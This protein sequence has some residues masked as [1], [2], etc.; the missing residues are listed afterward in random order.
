MGVV[1]VLAED[2]K[3]LSRSKMSQKCSCQWEERQATGMT[4]CEPDDFGKTLTATQEGKLFSLLF[5]QAAAWLKAK[6]V[7]LLDTPNQPTALIFH[8]DGSCVSKQHAA[9]DK[10]RRAVLQQSLQCCKLLAQHHDAHWTRSIKIS[11]SHVCVNG[12]HVCLDTL[13]KENKRKMIFCTFF[14]F[15]QKI[16]LKNSFHFVHRIKIT[17]VFV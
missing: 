14:C 17:A 16:L 9:K 10:R 1:L 15:F 7:T 11:S 8:T 13:E 12:S 4:P 5:S 3:A 2:V 6:W